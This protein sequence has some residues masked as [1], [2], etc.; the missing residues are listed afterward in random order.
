[1]KDGK[2]VFRVR[3]AMLFYFLKNLGLD[4]RIDKPPEVQQVVVANWQELE[5]T[6]TRLFSDVS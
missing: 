4:C 3:E 2:R 1:M 6:V 5:P